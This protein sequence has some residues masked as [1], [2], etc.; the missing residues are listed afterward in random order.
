[1]D[2]REYALELGRTSRPIAITPSL[3]GRSRSQIA[4]HLSE[5]ESTFGYV[6]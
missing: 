2:G 5:L 6:R 4:E 1:M 3:M